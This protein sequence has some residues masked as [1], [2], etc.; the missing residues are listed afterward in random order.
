LGKLIY[1]GYLCP[2]LTHNQCL[3]RD[4]LKKCAGGRLLGQNDVILAHAN[5]S[6]VPPNQKINKAEEL[7][8]L[9]KDIADDFALFER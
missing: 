9:S 8:Y 3:W 5:S 1:K 2:K 7:T 4:R 6:G